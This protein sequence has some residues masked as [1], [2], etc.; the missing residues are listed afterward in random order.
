MCY[1]IEDGPMP[2]GNLESFLQIIP[3]NYFGFPHYASR[4][5]KTKSLFSVCFAEI[6]IGLNA[7][8]FLLVRFFT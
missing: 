5:R 2:G 3:P 1:I 4:E 7:C 8:K 6:G